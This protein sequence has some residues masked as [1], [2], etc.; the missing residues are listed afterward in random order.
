MIR[1]SKCCREFVM[2][3]PRSSKRYEDDQKIAMLSRMSN[4]TTSKS[5]EGDQKIKVLSRISHATTPR[6]CEDSLLT[7]LVA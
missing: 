2:Q 4:A 1:R 7:L 5:C 6:R 3:G